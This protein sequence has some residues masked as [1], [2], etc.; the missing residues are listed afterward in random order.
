[1]LPRILGFF[2]VLL[3]SIFVLD[4]FVIKGQRSER[5]SARSWDVAPIIGFLGAVLLVLGFVEATRREVLDAWRWGIAFGFL[6]TACAGLAMVYRANR[7]IVTKKTGW[8]AWLAIIKTYGLVVLLALLGVIIAVRVIG[9]LL[10]VFVAAAL[11]TLVI[12]I[13]I[14]IVVIHW[15][16]KSVRIADGES[17][18]ADSK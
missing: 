18:I 7:P 4:W 6:L 1:M 16:R 9:A 11:G 2:A 12:A 10:E 15:R 3:I 8:R 17:Q 5:S 13:A 14:V